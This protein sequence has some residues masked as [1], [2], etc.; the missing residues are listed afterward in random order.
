MTVV[1]HGGYRKVSMVSLVTF[2]LSIALDRLVNNKRCVKTKYITIMKVQ[3]GK[4]MKNPS[5]NP[6]PLWGTGIIRCVS[7]ETFHC[8][9]TSLEGPLKENSAV[10]V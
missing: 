1:V 6:F 8:R 3:K 7:L 2:R 9:C 10:D 4:I 5:A